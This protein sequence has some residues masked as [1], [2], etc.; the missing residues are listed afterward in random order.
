M[1][2]IQA[3]SDLLVDHMHQQALHVPS[4]PSDQSFLSLRLK[5]VTHPSAVVTYGFLWG[6]FFFLLTLV[7]EQLCPYTMMMMVVVVLLED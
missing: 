4:P 7:G 1:E 3:A 6:F 2:L 5:S